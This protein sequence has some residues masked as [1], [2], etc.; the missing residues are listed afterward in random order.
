MKVWTLGML[1]LLMVGSGATLIAQRR[2]RNTVER[3]VVS[4]NAVVERYGEGVINWSQGYVEATGEAVY[5][6]GKPKAQ[7]RLMARRGAMLDAQR[8]LL[9][10]LMGVRISAASIMRDYE[11]ISDEV[12]T[13]LEGF[14]KGAQ[15]VREQDKGDSYLV[16]MR[17][18]LSGDLANLVHTLQLEPEQIDPNLSKEKSAHFTPPVIKPAQTPLPSPP[19]LPKLAPDLPKIM[20]G[21]FTGL[22]IDC[23]GLGVWPSMSPKIRRIDGSEL[24]GTLNVSPEYVIEHGIVVYIRDSKDLNHPQIVARIGKRPLVVRAVGAVGKFRTDPLLFEEDAQKVV[25]ENKKY[26]FLDQ[27]RVAFIVDPRFAK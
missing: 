24:W 4:V 2:D 5:P 16:V 11:V 26:R 25:E 17:I 19:P 20:E 8:N 7:A 10:T 14:I 1:G 15:V 23:R 3:T 6:Q 9:E 21:P 12:R 18:P 13:T 27:L 22:V